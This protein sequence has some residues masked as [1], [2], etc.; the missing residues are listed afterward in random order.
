MKRISLILVLLICNTLFV[1]AQRGE[2]EYQSIQPK[3][4]DLGAERIFLH[5]NTNLFFPGE[6]LHYKIYCFDTKTK[7]F[8]SI[9]KIGY[10]EMV[11]EDGVSIF[12]HKITL[13]NGVGYGDYSMPGD[14][15][16]GSYKLFAYTN[17]MKN[18]PTTNFF[19][20]D[21][22]VIN[23]YV[24]LPTNY[25]GD[26]KDTL[27]QADN[28]QS[29]Q[30]GFDFE[31]QESS[32]FSLSGQKNEKREKVTVNFSIDAKT[33]SE[34]NYSLSVQKV[35]EFLSFDPST[36]V[37][38]YEN[39]QNEDG[40]INN[41]SKELL[42]LPE[43]RG[44]LISGKLHDTRTGNAKRGETI[45]LSLFGKNHL[46]KTA[47]T[48]G[49]GHFHFNI[50]D[51]Q[52]NSAGVLHL[53][54]GEADSTAITLFEK[55]VEHKDLSFPAYQIADTMQNAIEERSIQNQIENAFTYLKNDSL[56]SGDL[57]VPFYRKMDKTYA[58]SDYTRFNTL[59]ETIVEIVD[60][61]SIK[62]NPQGD[63]Y[64]EV[65]MEGGFPN[66]GFRSMLFVDGIF[67]KNQE[68]FMDYD[69]KD[70]NSIGYKKGIFFIGSL[71]YQGIVSI[72]TKNSD[73]IENGFN[74][75][76]KVLSLFTP[77]ARKKYFKQEYPQN[78]RKDSDRIPDFRRQLLWIP[79][80]SLQEESSVEFFTSDVTGLFKVSLEGLSS[81]G[82]PVSSF[83][84]LLVE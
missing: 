58:L 18:E 5:Y 53:L 51:Y 69:S 70:I 33:M 2:Q 45:A 59:K 79:N 57:R 1:Y 6:R 24:K 13:E 34:G 8:S 25:V 30:E 21:L 77:K 43:L 46:F 49:L 74:G 15:K 36:I 54:S 66:S 31:N 20:T 11:S 50:E 26:T 67:I 3:F 72:Q 84:Y 44:S 62:K 56:S 71:F 32:F 73:Y 47:T 23:P 17:W 61:V 48:D 10:L 60:K 29:V 63:R 52:E 40:T 39:L 12:K 41:K 81:E 14:I 37:E 27:L 4:K 9:S 82:M 7:D 38:F 19:E 22:V 83:Q 65:V 78:S 80:L 42:F 75:S 16:S 64:F 76:Q 35:D 68:S 28:P 55:E